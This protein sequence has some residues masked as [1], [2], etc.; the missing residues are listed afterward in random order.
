MKPFYSNSYEEAIKRKDG[1][2]RRSKNEKRHRIKTMFAAFAGCGLALSISAQEKP[3]DSLEGKKI[4]LDEVVVSASRATDKIPVTFTNID[5]EE[6]QKVNLGQD[7][8]VLLNYMPSVVSTTFDGT[9]I[10]PT[11][12]RIRG[13]DNSRIN[14]TINGIPYNDADSQTTFFVNLQ[15][16]AS[17]IENIQIQRGVG[18]STNGAGAFGASVNILTDNYSKEAFGQL[19]NSF[20]SFNSRK[21]SVRFSTG[22]LNDHFAFSGRLSR[23]KSDGYVDRAFSDL[24]S[25]FLDGVYKDE[26][27]L[28]K[29]VVFGGEE[30]TGLSFF[31]LNAAGLEEN[32]TFNN[33][34]L[35]LD[36]DGNVQFYDRQ[37][38]NYKQDHYQLHITQQFGE[39]WTGNISLHY[40]KGRGFFEQYIESDPSFFN[41]DLDFYRLPNFESNGETIERSDLVTERFLNSNFYGTVFSLNYKDSKWDA[42]FGGGFNRYDGEQFGEITAAEFAQLPNIPFRFYENGTD[43]RDFNVYAKATYQLNEQFSLFGDLQLRTID[44]EAS[45][46]LFDPSG[47]LNVDQ[48]FSFFNPKTGITYRPNNQ[49]SI[50]FSYARANREP[51]RVDFETGTPE[52][53]SLND[54]EL[55]W[56]YVS[57]NFQLNT[58]VYY[59]DFKNQLVLTGEL[60]EVGFPIRQNSGQS[61]RLG[62]EIDANITWDKFSIRPNLAVSTNKNQDFLVEDGTDGFTN[63]GNTNISFSPEIIAGNIFTYNASDSFSASLYSKYVGQQFMTNTDS[64][65][66]DA[67]FVNDVNVQYTL[68]N[69]S[70][71]KSV[72]FTGQVNNIFDLDY[73]NNGYVFDG[74]SFF[75]PQAGINF[76]LGATLNF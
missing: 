61:Y 52:P 68:T 24:R 15:D 2:M 23:I 36:S 31:G 21:H 39:N 53:E 19:S 62:L 30:I 50:Y 28:I 29:A 76:L 26:N 17:S 8:P 46:A 66:I 34:G 27:T 75:Y 74:E 45:G 18:T 14:V 60:D 59:L 25:Y 64:N 70:I 37:T 71:L 43:K 3:K 38:D 56:R 9:G 11:D 4:N 72:V 57:P 44:Y 12:F 20:G 33:D 55:G 69:I 51:A 42:V 6:I 58:N 65:A 10:G 47:V 54:F 22:L 67:Y 32:R 49:N 73:E 35:Y 16:F 40:T 13:A 41:G 63:L 1:S 5:R 7:I 48:N